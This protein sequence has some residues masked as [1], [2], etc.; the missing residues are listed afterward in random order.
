M[1]PLLSVLD[2]SDADAR[3]IAAETLALFD[4][5]RVAVVAALVKLLQDPELAPRCAAV[6]S[7]GIIGAD[8]RGA[9]PEMVE[10]AKRAQGLSERNNARYWI[11]RIEPGAAPELRD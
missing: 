5:N 4:H 1:P 8:A 2:D 11:E 9:L 7:L 3:A 10:Y 6:S